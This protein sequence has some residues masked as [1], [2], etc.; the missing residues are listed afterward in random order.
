MRDLRMPVLVLAL[1]ALCLLGLTLHTAASSGCAVAHCAYLPYITRARAYP[2]GSATPAPTSTPT[3]SSTPAPTSTPPPSSTPPP[4]DA[5]IALESFEGDP[6]AWRVTPVASGGGS[7]TRSEHISRAGRAAARAATTSQNGQARIRATFADAASDHP[8]EERPGTWVWQR[9]SLYLPAA[10]VARLGPNNYL[11]IAGMEASAAGYGWS[12]QVRQQ[13]ELYVTGY[14]PTDGPPITFRIY[15]RFPVER[16]AQLEIGLHSQNGPGVKRA[17]AL[18]I[19]GQ[20]YGWY[21]Q[22]R[23]HSETYDRA[24]MGILATNSDEPLELY[25]DAWHALTQNPLPAGPDARPT[26]AL[27]EQDYRS[28]SGV[29]WQIDWTTWQND[30]RLDPQHGLYSASDR[31]QSGRNLDR[32]PPL[33]SGWAEIEIDWPRG[34]PPTRPNG[35]FGP[36]VG[37]RKEIN[38]EQNLEVIPIGNG[39]GT[40]DLVLEAWVG[41]PVILQRWPLPVAAIGGT[42]IPEPGDIV[43]ARWEQLNAQTLGVRASYYDAS[44]ARWY[45]NIIDAQIDIGNIA[46]V[47]YTADFHTASSVTIDSPFYAIRRFK[48]G[49]LAT[50]P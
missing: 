1:S 3:A 21:H 50:Y 39:D 41:S 29:Q 47:E 10:T 8:W 25:L 15:G 28:Q 49:T 32:M 48:V 45:T 11:T 16:W 2:I 24:E 40:V 37:F 33:T 22:G 38:R 46:G 19:D 17:F 26:T 27:Q 9:A 44:A 12:L 30:L 31:L 6:T 34:Q 20:F 18:L 35:Y 14:P 4:D 36:M 7:V 5:D 23:M 13:G 43:R 42:Q